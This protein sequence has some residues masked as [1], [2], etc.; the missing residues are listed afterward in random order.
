[1]KKSL[2]L[3]FTLFFI[4]LQAFAQENSNNEEQ[5][6]AEDTKSQE[7]STIK[8]DEKSI[9]L[10]E[11][12][13]TLQ[14]QKMRLYKF[15]PIKNFEGVV[16]L[17]EFNDLSCK[18]CLLKSKKVYDSIGEENLKNLRI[19]YK[20]IN[21][22]ALNLVNQMTVY[23]MAAD[24]FGVFWEF[25]E[26][27]TN[28]NI[29]THDEIIELLLSLGID[30]K[31]LLDDLAHGAKNYYKQLDA[32]VKFANSIENTQAPMIFVDGYRVND[33]F[34]LEEL[35]EYISNQIEKFKKQKDEEENKYKMGKF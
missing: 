26:A 6:N 2:L 27:I 13:E 31:E 8:A 12:L 32:D 11:K 33:D 4:S 5:V 1:M 14:V 21:K 7:E 35:N 30:K 16:T 3:I 20:F 15:N 22:D 9:S 34:T 28:K 29:S 17:V 23:A 25:K 19:I 10:S 24:E 18:E